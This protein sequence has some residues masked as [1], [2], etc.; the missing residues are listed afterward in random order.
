V[1]PCQL[2]VPCP[3]S[4]MRIATPRDVRWK[5]GRAKALRTSTGG[6]IRVKEGCTCLLP[7]P[8]HQ[9]R[10]IAESE[11]AES[12]RSVREGTSVGIWGPGSRPT[13]GRENA[14]ARIAKKDGGGSPGPRH[15]HRQSRQAMPVQQEPNGV[16]KTAV[17][18]QAEHKVNLG[19]APFVCPRGD[20][21]RR[22]RPPARCQGSSGR[23]W[24]SVRR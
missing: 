21:P 18:L 8:G 15:Q 7:G 17:R 6:R 16:L 2:L 4:G 9:H 20:R 1:R 22:K 12:E 13:D 19:I 11:F 24:V 23:E 14:L 5:K 3:A 10:P